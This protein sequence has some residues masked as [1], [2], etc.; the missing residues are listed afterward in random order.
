MPRAVLVCSVETLQKR[1]LISLACTQ[2]H[3][4]VYCEFR[5]LKLRSFVREEVAKFLA[6]TRAHTHIKNSFFV[7]FIQEAFFFCKK[8]ITIN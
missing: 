8:L 5:T 2:T 3:L 4:Y 6:E 1:V 7:W